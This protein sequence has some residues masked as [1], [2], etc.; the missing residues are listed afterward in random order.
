MEIFLVTYAKDYD[1]TSY[2]LRSI[3]KFGSGFSGVTMVV[4]SGDESRFQ[5]LARKHGVNLRPYHE[6]AAKGFLHHQVCKCEADLW[7]PKGTDLVAHID[8]DCMFKEPFSPDTFMR[9]GKPILVRERYEDF[10]HY[11]A[12]Y[13]WKECVE[14]ALGIEMPWE[15]MVRHPGV[16]WTGMY[17]EMRRRIEEVH[18]MPFT[19]FVLAQRNEFPQTF[20]EFPTI[21][22]YALHAWA[23]K[24]TVVTRVITPS[25]YWKSSGIEPMARDV[26][27]KPV[28]ETDITLWE[29]WGRE[30]LISPVHYFW[31]RAGVTP[32]IRGKL[33]QILA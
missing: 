11:P 1:F 32:E 29:D 20:A 14:R 6:Y 2:T 27:G 19:Q 10:R 12:R 13:S 16:F 5:P 28:G 8:A 25:E 17:G 7:C 33:E 31:S 21:G 15:T 3:D 26:V 18:Q 30:P 4:P 9:G 22:G 24:C 23:Q